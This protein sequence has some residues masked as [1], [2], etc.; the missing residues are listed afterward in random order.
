M[1]ATSS[2]KLI[3]ELIHIS[4]IYLA[5]SFDIIQLKNNLYPRKTEVLFSTFS[6]ED[7]PW[8]QKKCLLGSGTQGTK[9]S[10]KL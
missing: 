5:I 8:L 3:F 2:S 7:L 4:E 1:K 10:N 6:A 9:D